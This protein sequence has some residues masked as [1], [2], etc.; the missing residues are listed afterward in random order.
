MN[1]IIIQYTGRKFCYNHFNKT[2]KDPW[3]KEEKEM[4]NLNIAYYNFMESV[5]RKLEQK[6]KQEY[7]DMQRRKMMNVNP[8]A[9]LATVYGATFTM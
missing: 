3:G 6:R 7:T 8:N 9:R 2:K 4:M 5:N 1:P